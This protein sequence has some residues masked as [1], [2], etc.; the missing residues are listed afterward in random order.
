ME[1]PLIAPRDT[2]VRELVVVD[3]LLRSGKDLHCGII[4]S[5][6]RS[7]M[8]QCQPVVDA[9]PMLYGLNKISM[10]LAVAL[11]H[12][13]LDMHLYYSCLGRRSNFRYNDSS[14]IWNSRDPKEYFQ[15]IFGDEEV[16]ILD[17]LISGDL[18]PIFV[19]MTHEVLANASVI[20]EAF[21]DLRMI[22][23]R[24]NPLDLVYSW[25][26]RG[27]SWRIGVEPRSLFLA[28]QGTEGPVPWWTAGWEQ[29]YECLAPMD[30]IIRSVIWLLTREM[31]QYDQLRSDQQ[32]QIMIASYEWMVTNSDEYLDQICNHIGTE[33]SANTP[34][35]MHEERIPRPMSA[36][37]LDKR[38]NV[39]EE[40]ATSAAFHELM[41]ITDA[42]HA[43]SG[44]RFSLD[45]R[46]LR[47]G[48][49]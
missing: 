11:L 22:Y 16:G 48:K 31:K 49:S 32:E 28:L 47:L 45:T 18:R 5:L 38:T 7:E 19:L 3:G 4:S 37:E 25:H 24:R 13:E 15:R 41:E 34:S 27:Y 40:K 20:F 35:R 33:P 23:A 43:E 30:K 42:Y 17:K 14:S 8:W 12:L 44:V 39:I 21:P 26:S 9:V 1:A 6:A 2:Y 10:D 46:S 36:G 29:E